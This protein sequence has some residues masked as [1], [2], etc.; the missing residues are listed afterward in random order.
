[1][2]NASP[3]NSYIYTNYCIVQVHVHIRFTT[4]RTKAVENVGK[5]ILDVCTR[6]LSASA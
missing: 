3:M 1:M 2:A 4:H 5:G 6:E